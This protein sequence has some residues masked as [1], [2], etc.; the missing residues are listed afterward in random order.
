LWPELPKAKKVITNPIV[1][2][3]MS[4]LEWASYR[5][6]HRCIGLS[7][8]IVDGIKERG[9]SSE[10]ISMIPNGCDLDIFSS[11]VVPW[12]PHEVLSTDFMAVYTGTHGVANGL[13]SAIDVAQELQHRQRDDIKL[14][15]VGQGKLKPEL[16][17]RAKNENINNVIFHESVNKAKLAGIMNSADIGMQLLSNIPAFY[18]G[19][20]PNKFFDYISAGLPVINNYPGWLAGI[21][22]EK[23][24]GFSVEP[25][26]PQIFA[27]ALVEAAD[28]RDALLLM[29]ENARKLAKSSFNREDLAD[30]WVDWVVGA[31]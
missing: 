9:V 8:G 24:C 14:V 10:K 11:E 29:G 21:I 7:P 6:A 12:R 13:N 30:K 19:T 25:D 23:N 4:M 27:D 20:S 2:G 28:N 3:L 5:S 1:L 17:T 18:Y 31:K 15:F 22:E 16:V 26:S